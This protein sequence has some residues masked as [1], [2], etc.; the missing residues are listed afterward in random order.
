MK[1]LIQRV[2]KASVKVS[3][4]VISQIDRGLL[5]L[6]GVCNND[7]EK[8]ITKLTEKIIKLR[9]FKDNE[10]K[11]NKSINDIG[12]KILLV[13]QFTLCSRTKKG[14]R[15]SFIDA[16]NPELANKLY[17]LMKT[18]LKKSVSVETG[19]FGA[20]MHIELV[21]DGPVTIML[22]TKE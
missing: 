17:E 9:V 3:D 2:S 5:I 11:M 14:N 13:S 20:Y 10:G 16:A 22:D 19:K 12:G 8:D 1:A 21:N 15:P 18:E 4:E 7:T 6:L